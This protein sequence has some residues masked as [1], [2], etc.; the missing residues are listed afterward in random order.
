MPVASET[1]P[2][3]AEPTLREQVVDTARRLAHLSHEARMAK[4][5]ATDAI[6]D[7]VY[8]ARRAVKTAKRDIAD[9][10]DEAVYRIKKQPLQAVGLA[11]AAG[12]ATGVAVSAIAW[13][14]VRAT[15]A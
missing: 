3:G 11:F 6:E 13:L 4:S 12:V 9:A 8:Q 5:L 7:R 1:T 14:V 15:R 10:R 2:A